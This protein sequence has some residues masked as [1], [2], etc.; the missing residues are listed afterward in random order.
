M[1]TLFGM[2]FASFTGTA[3][4]ACN[5]ALS[6]AKT[7]KGKTLISAF[8]R[9]VRCDRSVA[10]ENFQIFVTRATDVDT[11][12][13]LSLSAIE[14]D[15]W[16]PLW[17]MPGLIQDYSTRDMVTKIIGEKCN[18]NEK[19]LP[20][21]QGAYMALR[22][23][24][25][26]RWN[27]A[28]ATCQSEQL[29]EW[30]SSQ[31]GAPP[32]NEYDDKYATLMDAYIKRVG[33]EAL[34]TLQTAA[35]SASNG[36]GP[37]NSII[38]GMG[39]SV[40]PSLGDEITEENKSAL[41]SAMVEVAKQV[42]PDRAKEV[43]ERLANAGS[44]ATAASLLTSI[45][46]DRHSSGVFTYGA[47]AIELADCD[48]TKTAVLHVIEVSDPGKRWIISDDIEDSLR[49]SKAKLKKCS[50]EG[51]WGISTTAEPISSGRDLSKWVDDLKN[52]YVEKGYDVS[53]KSEKN[54]ALD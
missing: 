18:D 2:V 25:F 28:Y 21:L 29:G 52:I 47:A 37:F 39:S 22:N 49:S 41:E 42:G 24:D 43:A 10:E 13:S 1:L 23:I 34:T 6:A 19:I 26:A 50:S 36:G 20:F 53:Q 5:S 4:A 38:T 14:N 45:Y 44:E 48:G 40:A 30:M 7:A 17:K 33:P 54:I 16:M 15:V 51:E 32:A 35:I 31:V 27:S 11:L 12:V 9:T 3:E 46:P 8:E